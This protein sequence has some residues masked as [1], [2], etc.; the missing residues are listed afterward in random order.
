MSILVSLISEQSIPNILVIKSMP[1]ISRYLF[2]CSKRM[3]DSGRLTDLC[4]L[5]GI[6]T[7][8]EL[9]I[10]EHDFYDIRKKLKDAVAGYPQDTSYLINITGGTKLMALAVYDLMSSQRAQIIYLPP[11]AEAAILIYPSMI[12]DFLP[13]RYQFDAPSFLQA[14]GIKGSFA[15]APELLNID[16]LFRYIASSPDKNMCLWINQIGSINE[17]LSLRRKYLP[18]L[19]KLM[20]TSSPGLPDENQRQYLKGGWFESYLAYWIQR[21]LPKA[22][23]Y[24]NMAINRESSDNELDLAFCYHNIFYVI[25]VKTSVSKIQDVKDYLYKLDSL[26]KKFG[27][28]PRRCLAIA[29]QLSEQSLRRSPYALQRAQ[30][31]G[32]DVL[33]YSDLQPENIVKTLHTWIKP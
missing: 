33:L 28:Y 31:M 2:L 11:Q 25:E 10:A 15:E 16:A 30:E 23:L 1:A 3:K 12:K 27:L 20:D 21:V 9:S 19:S 32:I 26:G 17:N 13:I 29:H 22:K 5:C 7:Y 14:Y 6:D 4:E 24:M 18:T 8:D